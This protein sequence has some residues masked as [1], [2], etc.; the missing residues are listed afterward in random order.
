[1][2]VSILSPFLSVR[3]NTR[4]DKNLEKRVKTLQSGT[5]IVTHS[6]SK[7]KRKKRRFLRLIFILGRENGEKIQK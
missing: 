6:R 1:V 4:A 5:A 7:Q 2:R 3:E